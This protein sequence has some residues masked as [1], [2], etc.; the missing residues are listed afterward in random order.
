MHVSIIVFDDFTD[1]DVFFLWDLLNRV[2]NK[3]WQV[4]LLGDKDRHRSKAG[5]EIPMHGHVSEASASRA[6]LFAS[7]KGVQQ[8]L[9]DGQFLQALRLNPETQLIGSMCS[10]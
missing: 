4:R 9:V 5:L 3:E 8:K 1:I 2:K 10:G 6:V 7:G